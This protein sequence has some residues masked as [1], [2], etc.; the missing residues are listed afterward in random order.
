M[1]PVAVFTR[2]S[3]SDGGGW[4]PS[5]ALKP[6]NASSDE[7]VTRVPFAIGEFSFGRGQRRLLR[8]PDG[9]G[10][11]IEFGMAR[12]SGKAFDGAPVKIARGKIHRRELAVGAQRGIDEAHA[13][14]KIRPIDLGNHAHAG[15]DIAHGHIEGALQT[16]LVLDDAIWRGFLGSEALDQ[17][18][19]RRRNGLILVAKPV[20]QLRGKG[21]GQQ[22]LTIFAQHVRQR[23]G[24]LSSDAE[25]TV[26]KNVGFLARLEVPYD[27][28]RQAAQ[29]LH[30][31]DSQCDR[32]RPQL[33]DRQRLYPLIGAHEAHQRL[34]IEPAVRVGN[35]GPG[36]TEDARISLEVS[37]G[38]F[39]EL[40]IEAG[41]QIGFD[42]PDLFFNDMKIVEQPFGRRRDGPAALRRFG[43]DPVGLCQDPGIVRKP[44]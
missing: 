1:H 3:H 30:Q 29:I 8:A 25:Q 23:L 21:R 9:A 24:I 19:M 16:Q 27:G 34:E 11:D 42:L 2:V 41:R 33:A 38:Q 17:P 39:G 12:S 18:F 31:D 32:Y 15:D 20:I 43:N 5:L 7:I 22:P 13:L 10:R 36:Q 37:A 26:C 6:A 40:V 44:R 28:F 4:N 35:E 14:E